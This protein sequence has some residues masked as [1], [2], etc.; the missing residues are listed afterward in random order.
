[1]Y[2]LC[3]PVCKQ[4]FPRHMYRKRGEGMHKTCPNCRKKEY[5][6]R[7]VLRKQMKQAHAIIEAQAR[8]AWI[9]KKTKELQVEFNRVS[10]LNRTRIRALKANENPT[11]A[12]IR[13]L[14]HREEQ[15][16][17]WQAALE[18]M[19]TKVAAGEKITIGLREY[20]SENLCTD[21]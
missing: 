20:Y 2:T 7:S 15:Q 6:R 16:A 8:E 18:E 19:L 11:K 5:A 12:T 10:R 17:I 14:A 21:T 1:M 4:H 13:N 9:K 3:C